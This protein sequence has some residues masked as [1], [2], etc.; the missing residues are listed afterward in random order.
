MKTLK[1]VLVLMS[2]LAV[3][4]AAWAQAGVTGSWITTAFPSAV[5]GSWHIVITLQAN[6]ATLTGSITRAGSAPF[7]IEDGKVEGATI[8]FK[9]STPDGGRIITYTGR[10]TGDQIAF[11][12][13]VQVRDAASNGGAGIFGAFGPKQFTARRG[14]PESVAAALAAGVPPAAAAPPTGWVRDQCLK[15]DPGKGAEVVAFI[16]DDLAKLARV[17]VDEGRIAWWL[18]LSAVVPAGSDARCDFHWVTGYNGF[19]PE[20]QTAEQMAAELKRAGI[21]MTAAEHTAKAWSISHPVNLDFWHVEAETGPN[22]ENGQYVRLNYYKAKPGGLGSYFGLEMHWKRFVESL[23]DSHLGWHLNELEMPTGAAV[24]YD[25]LTVDTYPT[26][27]ALGQGWPIAEW[28]KVH[29]DLPFTAYINSINETAEV[30]EEDVLR[31]VESVR[32]K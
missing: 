20:P 14:T 7:D 17:A 21:A 1:A 25:A 29:P 5:V 13:T 2:L 18:A 31:V 30:Y 3:P 32:P 19:P 8:T 12:R 28:P 11:T 26:W 9:A 16:H 4:G 27:A 10:V 6:G 24:R 15:A 22:L 23:K